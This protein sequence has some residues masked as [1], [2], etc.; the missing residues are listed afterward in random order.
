MRISQ[1]ETDLSCVVALCFYTSVSHIFTASLWI[2][3]NDIRNIG[4]VPEH[5]S[6]NFYNYFMNKEFY[7]FEVL[8]DTI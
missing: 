8:R 4:C 1:T 5:F 6:V 2:Q 3:C 7:G